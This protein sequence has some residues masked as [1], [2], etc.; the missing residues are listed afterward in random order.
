MERLHQIDHLGVVALREN[1]AGQGETGG[2]GIGGHAGYIERLA[3]ILGGAGDFTRVMQYLA[4][5]Q[6]QRWATGVGRT[7]ESLRVKG[8]RLGP[9]GHQGRLPS[10]P[11]CIDR[12]PFGGTTL[13]KV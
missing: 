6:K 3:Q 2:V 8:S 5:R 11:H 10:G 12:R 4:E 13:G 1:G 7:S 9:R